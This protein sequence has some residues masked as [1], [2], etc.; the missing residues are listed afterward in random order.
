MELPEIVLPKDLGNHIC[1]NLC[2]VVCVTYQQIFSFMS[3]PKVVFY[4][5]YGE[6]KEEKGP[7]LWIQLFGA[8]VAMEHPSRSAAT[9]STHHGS[10]AFIR[11]QVHL[12]K[13]VTTSTC[14]VSF[15]GNLRRVLRDSSRDTGGT[16]GAL[17]S[18]RAL[19]LESH[20]LCGSGFQ[21]N[22]EAGFIVVQGAQGDDQQFD[23]GSF[24][25]G[26]ERQ[27]ELRG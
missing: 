2:W 4:E 19:R 17:P 27:G 20:G 24:R 15:R 3:F 14:R 1:R 16:P 7:G 12:L 22:V 21:F 6:A 5:F 11:L 26:R 18:S 8:L 9:K 23:C 10:Q 13:M 25:R